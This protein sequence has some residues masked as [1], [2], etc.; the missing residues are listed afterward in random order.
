[1]KKYIAIICSVVMTCA[2][3]AGCSDKASSSSSEAKATSAVVSESVAEKSEGGDYSDTYAA[4]YTEKIKSKNFAMKM[5]VDNEYTGAMSLTMEFC[6]GNYHINLDS[7]AYGVEMYLV[8]EKMYI[9]DASTKTYS[10]MDYSSDVY[11]EEDPVESGF[12]LKDGYEFVGSEET[13]DGMVCET[14]TYVDEIVALYEDSSA[15]DAVPNQCKYYFDKE[16]GDLKKI[17]VTESGMTETIVVDSFTTDITEIT[18][19]DLTDW[20]EQSTDTDSELAED[21]EEIEEV[22]GDESEI[23]EDTENSDNE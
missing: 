21:E 22:L 19:P 7:D 23:A 6:G 5:S 4:A 2:V 3:F 14:F 17:E 1:M 10:V 12:G 9:M 16:S 20:T 11:G 18:L 15:S 8:D 13:D